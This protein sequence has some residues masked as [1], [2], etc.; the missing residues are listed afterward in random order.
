MEGV[1]VGCFVKGGVRGV[2]KRGRKNS[3]KFKV[4][5]LEYVKLLVQYFEAIGVKD[6]Q[7]FISLTSPKLH[8][9]DGRK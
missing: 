4:D 8:T 9:A 1:Q 7:K 2:D 5:L 3:V 6:R